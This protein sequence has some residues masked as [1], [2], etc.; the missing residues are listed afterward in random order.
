MKSVNSFLVNTS[1]QNTQE[2]NPADH[3]VFYN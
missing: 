1:K 2:F 3:I